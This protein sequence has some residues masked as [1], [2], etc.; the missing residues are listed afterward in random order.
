MF[1]NSK[2]FFFCKVIDF[3]SC[4]AWK[5]VF[6][7]MKRSASFTL[8]IACKRGGSSNGQRSKVPFRF[9]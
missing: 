5:V 7:S 9:D 1:L 8:Y 6:L 2:F 3:A 4:N